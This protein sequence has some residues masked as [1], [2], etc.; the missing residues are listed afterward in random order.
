[1]FPVGSVLLNQVSD[2]FFEILHRLPLVRPALGAGA[3]ERVF[4][5]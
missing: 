2:A 5:R 3:G 4:V 1:L